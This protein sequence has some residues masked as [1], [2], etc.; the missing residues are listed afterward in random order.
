MLNFFLK[1]WILAEVFKGS[2]K[3]QQRQYDLLVKE[4]HSQLN[5]Q[6]QI[7]VEIIEEYEGQIK[8]VNV[9]QCIVNF[10][11]DNPYG[12]SI[13]DIN[14]I[15]ACLYQDYPDNAKHIKKLLNE[16]IIGE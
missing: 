6:I 15:L 9:D 5:K 4:H 8:N 12:Y 2:A 7:F 10:L 3:R 11:V 14:H 13:E 16:I 1:S